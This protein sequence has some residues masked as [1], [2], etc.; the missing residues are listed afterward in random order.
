MELH[1]N[2]P[3]NDNQEDHGGWCIDYDFLS[4][5]NRGCGKLDNGEGY[6]PS[7]EETELVIRSLMAV[8]LS[9]QVKDAIKNS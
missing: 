1:I 2:I 4:K 9:R 7:L 5:V 8:A 6:Q 3:E